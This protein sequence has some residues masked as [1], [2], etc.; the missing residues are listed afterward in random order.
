MKLKNLF[1]MFVLFV[2]IWSLTACERVPARLDDFRIGGKIIHIP[3][4]AGLIEMGSARSGLAPCVIP[5]NRLVAAYIT[6][7]DLKKLWSSPLAME[8]YAMVQ[9]ARFREDKEYTEEQ[10]KADEKQMSTN[11]TQGDIKDL[12]KTLNDQAG[13]AG[14]TAI[15]LGM[16]VNMGCSF[17]QKDTFNWVMVLPVGNNENTVTMA[18]SCT[19]VRIH[20][21]VLFLYVYSRFDGKTTVSNLTAIA[22][23]WADDVLKAN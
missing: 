7:D 17:S 20:G 23:K 14:V 11:L 2:L 6:P 8:T 1:I 21:R 12:E 9:V 3:N 18:V 5:D 15:T 13:K 10:F 19:V 16:P 4:P 22:H